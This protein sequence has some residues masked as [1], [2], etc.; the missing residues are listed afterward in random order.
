MDIKIDI[1][2]EMKVIFKIISKLAPS[3]GCKIKYSGC[4]LHTCFS[5]QHQRFAQEQIARIDEELNKKR[6]FFKKRVRDGKQTNLK[7]KV[8]GLKKEKLLPH[9][10]F[11]SQYGSNRKQIMPFWR[12]NCAGGGKSSKNFRKFNKTFRWVLMFVFLARLFFDAPSC[13]S[14]HHSAKKSKQIKKNNFTCAR[15]LY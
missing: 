15:L 11:Q 12:P 14:R 9:I 8:Y 3:N 13:P 1:C 10:R 2:P 6:S 7:K 4:V 5:T